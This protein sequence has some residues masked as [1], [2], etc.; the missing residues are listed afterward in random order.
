VIKAVGLRVRLDGVEALRLDSLAVSRGERVGVRGP[1]G[2]GKTTLLR[3]LAGLLKP[4]EGSVEAPR[5]T[6]LVHQQPYFFRGTARENVAY[7]LKLNRRPVREAGEWL[8]RLGAESFADRPASTLSEGERRRVAVA[9]ALATRPEALLLDEPFAGLDA[10]GLATVTGALSA[11]EGTLMVAAP[12]L[13]AAPVDRV[14]D[15]TTVR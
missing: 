2:S 9:R 14:L 12:H 8:A 13:D 1:N 15:L 4:T 5:R 10:E 6:V 7:A 3:V 11:F